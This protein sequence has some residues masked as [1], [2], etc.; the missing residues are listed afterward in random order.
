MKLKLVTIIFL[1][2][3]TTNSLASHH[4]MEEAKP[5]SDGESATNIASELNLIKKINDHT[6]SSSLKYRRDD[7]RDVFG[8][9]LKY[10]KRAKSNLNYGFIA[11]LYDGE[12]NDN[13]W[14]EKNEAWV[15][16]DKNSVEL[17][18]SIFGTLR[19]PLGKSDT[20]WLLELTG[21]TMNNWTEKLLTIIPRAKLTYFKIDG[22]N[23]KYATYLE[24]KSY[25]PLNYGDKDIYKNSIYLG[26]LYNMSKTYKPY[27]FIQKTLESWTKSSEYEDDFP[28]QAGYD[29][30]SDMNYLGLGLNIYL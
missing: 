29:Y 22:S 3:I 28:G 11:H 1:I 23:F 13:D 18:T 12:R 24:L 2:S 26:L 17:A 19:L 6:Y 16:Y 25:I 7:Q 14:R 20:A 27:I 30:E 5:S 8:L 10:K 4:T 21:Q 9:E 15:W